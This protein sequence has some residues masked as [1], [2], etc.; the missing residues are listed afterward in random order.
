MNP[1]LS[2]P[3]RRAALRTTL[4]FAVAG[5]AGLALGLHPPGALAAPAPPDFDAAFQQF[6]RA[7][8]GDKAAIEPAAESF[9]LLSAGAPQ[10]P[11]LRAYLGAATALRATATLLPWRKMSFA[12]EGLAQ[13]DKALAQ[14]QPA[15][16][17]PAYRGVP[18]SLET[19]F[20][21]ASTFL[22][23]PSMFNRRDRGAR[24]LDDLLAHPLLAQA[25]L[26]FRANVW[27]GAARQARSEQRHDAARALLQQVAGS[28]TP[29]AAT[30]QALL[31][32]MK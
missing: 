30:A 29:Q 23:L 15:H 17:Q 28:G 21:A 8:G 9:G 3:R 13:I 31:K 6:Q 16:D 1:L 25:P 10:D 5:S 32:D 18:A 4:A 20:V 26:A 11:V 22:R 24:L 19:R 14:L 2:S 27:L 12:E 7:N